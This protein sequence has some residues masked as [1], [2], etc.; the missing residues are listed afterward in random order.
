MKFNIFEIGLFSFNLYVYCLTRGFI[1]P[2]RDFNLPTRAFN[3]ATRAYSLQT[4]EVELVTRGFELLTCQNKLFFLKIMVLIKTRM[5][6]FPKIR[7]AE[8]LSARLLTYQGNRFSRI[9][10]I[11]DKSAKL[12]S[13]NNL[14]ILW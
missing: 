7:K 6:C 9:Q 1:A 8:D 10:R 3:L 13:T 4:R 12:C 5:Y 14:K 11:F 2:T